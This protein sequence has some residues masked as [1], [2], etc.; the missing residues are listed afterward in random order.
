MAC[1]LL[2]A[3]MLPAAAQEQPGEALPNPEDIA[4]SDLDTATQSANANLQE[5]QAEIDLNAGRIEEIRAEIEALDGDAARLSAELV[6]AGRRVDLAAEDVRVIEERLEALFAEERGIRAR[7]DGH[8]R[9]IS[10]LLASLQRISANP[11]PAMIV[12]PSD[13]VGS[14]RAAMLLG[15]VLPQLQDSAAEV[16]EDLEALQA[17]K[18]DVEAEAQE[19]SANLQTLRE[20]RLRIS[21][22]IQ[23]RTRG[24]EWLSED[25]LVEQAEAQALADRATSLEQLIA[26]LET[27]IAA[28]TAADAATRAANAGQTVPPLDVETLRI[29]FSDAT[30]TEPAVPLVSARG[31]LAQ[32]VSGE[33]FLPY[34]AADGYGG[35]AQG[36][37][38]A[39]EPGDE[40][41]TPAD[42]WVVYKGPFLNYGQ[43]IILNAGQDYM[44]VLAGLNRIDVD[45]GQFVRMGQSLGTMGE[46]PIGHLLA[47]NPD[48]TGPTLYVELR[49]GGIPID[50]EGWWRAEPLI[51]ESGTS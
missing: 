33:S 44:I 43:I 26:G 39:A 8:D 10:G 18:S 50:P 17:L 48:L 27:R 37:A 23:A 36:I 16:T 4:N 38:I 25:L 5:V 28:V 12:N 11:P 7:L 20:E 1:A 3:A 49:E 6:A 31:F 13:A 40:V 30:R 34:G 46:S 24:M 35:T 29:A 2:A 14:A 15:S 51:A 45:E 32:P 47:A 42:G 19:L 22:I 41:V 21:T 9:S